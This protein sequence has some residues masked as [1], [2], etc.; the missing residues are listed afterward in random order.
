M[1]ANWRTT[2]FSSLIHIKRSVFQ[3][4]IIYTHRFEEVH[5]GDASLRAGIQMGPLSSKEKYRRMKE[6]I[7]ALTKLGGTIAASE[8]KLPARGYFVRPTVIHGF[9]DPQAVMGEV[10]NIPG[11]IICVAMYSDMTDA[12]KQANSIVQSGIAGSTAIAIFSDDVSEVQ[13]LCHHGVLRASAVVVNSLVD[14]PIRSLEDHAAR[15]MFVNETTV[16]MFPQ[17]VEDVT[18]L[19]K[20]EYFDTMSKAVGPTYADMAAAAASS[21]YVVSPTGRSTEHKQSTFER[22]TTM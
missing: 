19:G 7:E 2:D 18:Y 16:V 11:I 12:V 5:V 21:V 13:C 15:K 9:T 3:F 17:D 10:D 4:I 14:E 6:C 1:N 20:P 22:T 8:K